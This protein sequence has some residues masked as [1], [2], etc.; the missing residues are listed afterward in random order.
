MILH[1]TKLHYQQRNAQ[2]NTITN[3]RTKSLKADSSAVE[4]KT[5]LLWMTTVSDAAAVQ[6]E[7]VLCK[8]ENPTKNQKKLDIQ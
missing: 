5:Q 1:L 8:D 2:I 7:N 4:K 3:Q 6:K